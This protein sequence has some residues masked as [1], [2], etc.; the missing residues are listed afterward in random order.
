MAWAA[1]CG[2]F[3]QTSAA[4]STNATCPYTNPDPLLAEK[5]PINNH[6]NL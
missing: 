2:A 4:V 3:L 1:L 5:I 6:S